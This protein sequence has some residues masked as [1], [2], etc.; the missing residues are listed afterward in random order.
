MLKSTLKAI[1]LSLSCTIGILL[2][3][4][5]IKLYSLPTFGRV[6]GDTVNIGVLQQLNYLNTALKN[7]AADQMQNIYPE[8]YFFTHVLYGLSWCDFLTPVSHQNKLYKKGINEITA[9]LQQ[10]TS[11]KSKAIFNPNLPLQY[12]AFYVGWSNYLLAKK[13]QL[14]LPPERDTLDI[15]LFKTNCQQLLAAYKKEPIPYLESYE[16]AICPADNMLCL[17]SLSLHDQLFTPQYQVFLQSQI[18][19]IIK[20]LDNNTQLI[21]HSILP[22]DGSAKESARGSSQS[23]MLC[24]LPSIDSVLAK[25]QFKQYKQ[26][27]LSNRLGLIGISE[28]PKGMYGVGDIDSGPV[29][30]GIGGAAS[31]V[32]TRAM[33]AN[34]DWQLYGLM[35][36][37]IEALGLPIT[38]NQQKYYLNGD[39]TV[40]DAFIVWVNAINN[41]PNQIPKMPFQWQFHLYQ[42]LI[43]FVLLAAW[44]WIRFV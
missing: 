35:R 4:V 33:A 12:G 27:F 32:G 23:L 34:N 14:Q 30:L 2:F 28:Y 24:L 1:Y 19:Q 9:T 11:P 7:G 38:K 36:Q 22:D 42:L 15:Q 13:L 29:I 26:W 41:Q 37:N 3:Y 31:I 39:I 18:Q 40:A 5:T 8:G 25:I 17:A 20:Q 6:G 16:Y 44:R 10:L 21:P 43:V